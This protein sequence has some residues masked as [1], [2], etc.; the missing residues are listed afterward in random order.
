M[1]NQN[2]GYSLADVAAATGN[3]GMFGNEGGAWW[4]I[5][6]FLFCF[7]GGGSW[8]GNGRAA[9]AGEVQNDFNFASLERQN[10]SIIDNI[11]QASYDVTGAVKD[12][13]AFNQSMMKD[14]AYDING[15]LKDN[16]VALDSDIRDVKE[17]VLQNNFE[18][19]QGFSQV[20]RD[21][22]S[23]RYD[24]LLNTKE[25]LASN[26]AQTQ[27]ILDVLTG[28]RMA[29]MQNQINQL[30]LQSALSGVIRYP[31]ATTYSAGYSP[32][33]GGTCCNGGY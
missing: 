8:G 6:L 22:D 26:C 4:I 5:I 25:L 2:G 23:I 14:I 19:G 24:N 18:I 15:E 29:D 32:I 9:T 16:A 33:Y 30:Q 27:K 28:N 11:H 12:G 20:H 13:N 7:M 1:F 3:N 17:A 21:I 31:M 10:Q